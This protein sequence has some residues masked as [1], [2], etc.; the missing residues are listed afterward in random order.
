M[1][2]PQQELEKLRTEHAAHAQR[3]ENM[4]AR[5]RGWPVQTSPQPARVTIPP[6]QCPQSLDQLGAR[7]CA[8]GWEEEQ[9]EGTSYHL[10]HPVDK[11][12]GLDQL[13]A[14]IYGN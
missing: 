4:E 6:A 7:V 13:G 14:R 11:T 8:P 10:S 1:D 5:R 3:L 12:E 2:I 9:T